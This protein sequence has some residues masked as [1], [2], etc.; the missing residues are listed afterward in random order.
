MIEPG[1]EPWKVGGADAALEP[2][3][4][5]KGLLQRVQISPLGHA[6]DG[7]NMKAI[8]FHAQHQAGAFQ[9][10]IHR[11]RTRAA[12]AG[13]A[14]L[15]GPRGSVA[16]VAVYGGAALDLDRANQLH[17][18]D[19]PRPGG[20]SLVIADLHARGGGAKAKP[21][22]LGGDPWDLRDFL[23]FDEQLGPDQIHLHL[24]DDVPSARQ[25]A[26]HARGFG[27]QQKPLRS[28]FRALHI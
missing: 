10:A 24:N 25:N 28:S 6:L 26:A 13:G 5:Q 17:P 14:A 11:H 3:V 19:N 23:D 16:D 2:V 8:G 7:L 1:T 12:I 27:Q 18:F 21:A 4:E 9:H 15:L 20:A 22:I